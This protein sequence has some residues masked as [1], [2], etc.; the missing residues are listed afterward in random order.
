MSHVRVVVALK[1]FFFCLF[2]CCSEHRAKRKKNTL[3]IIV[4]PLEL[5]CGLD[6]KPVPENM[7][8]AVGLVARDGDFPPRAALARRQFVYIFIIQSYF[9]HKAK[10]GKLCSVQRDFREDVVLFAVPIYALN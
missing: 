6:E 4:P 2:F 10:G 9:S 5:S 1:F 8:C 7:S 3:G